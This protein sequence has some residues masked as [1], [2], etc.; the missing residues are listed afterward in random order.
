M[1]QIEWKKQTWKYYIKSS[2]CR[3]L[4]RKCFQLCVLISQLD[5]MQLKTPALFSCISYFQLILAKDFAT[6]ISWADRLKI[7]IF[8]DGDGDNGNTTLNKEIIKPKFSVE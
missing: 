4:C 2:M 1:K 8:V 6:K 3:Y 5:I 7:G